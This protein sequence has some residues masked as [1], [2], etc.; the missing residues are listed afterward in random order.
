MEQKRAQES[1][2]TY[3]RN[4]YLTKE[5]TT[6]NGVKT[7]STIVNCVGKLW[8][9]KIN[10]NYQL[11]P[12][13]RI[14]SKWINLN[15]S[16]ETIKTLEEN[17]GHKIS[18]I[19]HSNIFCRYVTQGKGNKGKYKQMGLHQT[20]NLLYSKGY[21]HQNEK[22]SY[23]MENIF[24]NDTSDKG[25]ISKIYKVLIQLNNRKTNNAI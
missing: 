23:C 25:L 20:K 8:Y 16:H 11:I 5:A 22:G 13:R 17:T 10:L 14:H 4:W 19:S 7:V 2:H 6:Y 21:Q 12:F 24:A 9:E 1:T 3:I 18:D 15:I